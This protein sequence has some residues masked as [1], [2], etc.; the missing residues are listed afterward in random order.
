MEIDETLSK[1]CDACVAVADRYIERS[2]RFG[3]ADLKALGMSAQTH[4]FK[5][6]LRHSLEVISDAKDYQ[7]VVT[8]GADDFSTAD[9]GWYQQQ[10]QAQARSELGRAETLDD[11][12]A[13]V[14]AQA[15]AA[16]STRTCVR[17]HPCR[18]F[19]SYKCGECHGS[20]RLTCHGCGGAGTVSCGV[21]SGSGRVS[22]SSCFGRG[23]VLETR[24]VRDYSGHYRTETRYRP[25][26]S[27]SGGQVLCLSCCGTGR[28]RCRTC[29]GSGHVTC[30]TCAGHGYLTRIT[31]TRTYTLPEF[32]GFYDEGTPDYVNQALYKAGFS[33]LEQ[34]GTIAFNSV[35]AVHEHAQ[36]DFIYCGAVNFCELSLDVAGHKSM[37]ILYGDK[38]RIHDAGGTLQALL[39][40]DFN[41]L[42]ALGT[43]SSRMLPWFHRRAQEVVAPFMESEV[44]REIVDA[45]LQGLTPGVIVE[46]V[47]RSVSAEYIDS[48]LT[49]LRQSIQVAARW[50]SLKWSLGIALASI[51]IMVFCIAWM[52][53]EKPHS[54]LATQ[55]HLVLFP[56]VYGP[57]ASWA[58]PVMSLPISLAGWFFARWISRRWINQAGG[59]LL[60]AWA[61]REGL[62]LGKWTAFAII[63]A[64][65]LSATIF[66]GKWPVWMDRDGKLYGVI[67]IFQQPELVEPAIY[68]SRQ[69]EKPGGARKAMRKH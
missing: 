23:S 7:G 32:Y 30:Q 35:E 64:T 38:P 50:S 40:E 1:Y 26:H 59:K 57:Q 52:E 41:R 63:A 37:W 42:D 17:T 6:G 5:I 55:S 27:C 21:C 62:L 18:L 53:H 20:G 46:K 8:P 16:I 39:I 29:G 67:A 24:Q 11:L 44:H 60:A 31:S 51:P 66:F 13:Q 49:G 36:A 65:A 14:Q 15:Y 33:N 19:H 25:C 48:S 22:C 61:H 12:V 43:E 45:D 10:V 68:R 2:T 4:R 58:I 34:Y 69:A 28:H 3:A 9:W 47:N 54:M 56:W